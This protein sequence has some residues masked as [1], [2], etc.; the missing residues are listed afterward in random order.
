MEGGTI[1]NVAL[2]NVTIKTVRTEDVVIAS[3]GNVAAA[4]MDGEI[5][6]CV[7]K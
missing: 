5:S 4:V 1:H 7:V 6:D 3:K 2:E